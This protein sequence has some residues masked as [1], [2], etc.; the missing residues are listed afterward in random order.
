[1]PS[2]LVVLIFLLLIVI[3]IISGNGA[4]ETDEVAWV[5]T[6]GIDKGESDNIKVT[7]RVAIP[8]ALAGSETSGTKGKE[9]SVLITL[10]AESLAE[11]RNLLKSQLSR[12]VS[13]S[14]TKT[15]II[16]EE[17]AKNGITNIMGPLMRFR[18]FRGSMF[19]MLVKDGTAEELLK[20]NKPD[21]E[22]LASRWVENMMH[23][24]DA[25][26]YYLPTELHDVYT[27][28]KAA[29]GSAYVVVA[30]INPKNGV[31]DSEGPLAN[32]E[33]TK[34]YEAGE[35]PKKSGNPVENIGV[36][37]FK[38]DKLAGY[39]T[40]EETR[41]LAILSNKFERGFISVNDPLLPKSRVNIA[42]R[43]GKKP[44]IN[45]D[46]NGENPVIHI[47]LLMEGEI[48]GNPAG[49]FYESPDY[50]SLLE[51]QLS[52]VVHEQVLNTIAKTQAWGAD[53]FDFGYYIRPK[54]STY[55]QLKD[56][57]WNS[58]YSSAVIDVKVKTEIRRMGLMRKT[59][60]VREN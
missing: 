8:V 5:I 32:G 25:T 40:N 13:L 47:N 9:N 53:P 36:G 22:T 46:L 21:L 54:F 55:Q 10:Q 14:Q 1:M 26:S 37:V 11:A 4:R 42:Y 23:T 39:L 27:R 20:A 19:F 49:I 45:V 33:K 48:T 38:G 50:L 16:G 12:E 59:S 52:N 2:R 3:S 57:N 30:A 17:A 60:P 6:I 24:S 29:T 28:L 34:Q 51:N 35:L 7:Y 43:N 41:I 58:R 15:I 44:S 56:Y 18:E 31:N